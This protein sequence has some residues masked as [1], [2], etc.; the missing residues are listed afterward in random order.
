D[1]EILDIT[2]APSV[3]K[4]EPC[5]K[6]ELPADAVSSVEEAAPVVGAPPGNAAPS[7]V[8]EAAPVAGAP[9]GNAAPSSVEEAAP[10]AGA[11]PD[12]AVLAERKQQAA[13]AVAFCQGLKRKRKALEEPVC[14]EALRRLAELDLRVVGEDLAQQA[15][16]LISYFQGQ[17]NK[18]ARKAP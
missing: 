8:E 10:I 7:S 11:P 18:R 12:D 1:W 6:Q 5:V 4:H 14:E 15:P 16:K 13:D 3:V 2:S 17:L 9:P